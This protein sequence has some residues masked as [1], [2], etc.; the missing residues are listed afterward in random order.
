MPMDCISSICR[1]KICTWRLFFYY[2][3]A[4]WRLEDFLMAN[5]TSCI[6]SEIHFLFFKE[7]VAVV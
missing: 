4:K 6:L 5:L 3:V 7:K 1:L 2:L